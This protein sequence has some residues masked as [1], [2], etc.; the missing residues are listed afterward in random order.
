MRWAQAHQNHDIAEDHIVQLQPYF[1]LRVNGVAL[2]GGGP[3]S[4]AS[5]A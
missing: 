3:L 1:P 2:G 5:R 4:E